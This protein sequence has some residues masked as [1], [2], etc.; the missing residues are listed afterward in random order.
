[1]AYPAF[2]SLYPNL[3]RRRNVRGLQYSNGVRPLPLWLAYT[4]FDFV[5]VLAGAVISIALFA[6][7]A[8][9]VWYHVGYV[10]VV[11][12]LHGLASI[13]LAYNISLFSANQLSAYAF[14]AAGQVILL[15]I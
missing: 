7:L 1:C 13:I 14:T 4:S 5:I 8:P 11:L 3:E 2:F 9:N 10:F 12:M 6:G 15:L